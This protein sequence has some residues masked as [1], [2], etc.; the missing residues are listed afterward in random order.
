MSLSHVLIAALAFAP[1]QEFESVPPP[2]RTPLAAFPVGRDRPFVWPDPL[3]PNVQQLTLDQLIDALPPISR[4][5]RAVVTQLGNELELHPLTIEFARRI[6]AGIQP[7]AD[8]W[9]RMLERTGNLRWRTRWPTGHP[10]WMYFRRPSRVFSE[11]SLAPRQPEWLAWKKFNSSCG[12]DYPMNLVPMHARDAG[13]LGVGHHTVTFDFSVTPSTGDDFSDACGARASTQGVLAFDVEIVATLEEV[14]TPV[15]SPALD[16]AVR[17]SIGASLDASW[18]WGTNS[19]MGGLVCE[20]AIGAHPELAAIGVSGTA[21]LL[22]DDTEVAS[23][24]FTLPEIDARMRAARGGIA[25]TNEVCFSGLLELPAAFGVDA[26]E[27]ARWSLRIE[28]TPGWELLMR[29][30]CDK[31]WRGAFTMP[32]TEALER[33]RSRGG[34]WRRARASED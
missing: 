26:S 30:S 22:R 10:V 11:M 8:Q 4:E 28:S 5:E 13:Q 32:L 2:A 21:H 31:A 7:T 33:E 29:W 9:R 27:L 12:M 19:A 20:A 25:A 6:D 16:A 17:A 24:S 15:S 34:P 18:Q 14:M 1:L 3:P 23:G